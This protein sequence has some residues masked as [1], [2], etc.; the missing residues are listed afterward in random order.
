[1][2]KG[3]TA[4]SMVEF[5]LAKKSHTHAAIS[6]D[7]TLEDLLKEDPDFGNGNIPMSFEIESPYKHIV[8]CICNWPDGKVTRRV[9]TYPNFDGTVT[10]AKAHIEHAAKLLNIDIE[11]D[12]PK[13]KLIK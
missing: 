10:N 6:L 4:V 11:W 13:L 3:K 1:M 2:S 8:I 9:A 12:G 7:M 5:D